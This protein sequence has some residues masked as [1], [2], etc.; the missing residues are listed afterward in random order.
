MKSARPGQEA[1]MIL[2]NHSDPL[3]LQA[4]KAFF[5]N[6]F[7]QNKN[8]LDKY[9]VVKLLSEGAGSL[10]FQFAEAAKAFKCFDS[11]GKPVFVCPDEKERKLIQEGSPLQPKSG[12]IPAQSAGLHVSAL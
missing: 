1:G 6:L 10:Q 5:N 2:R 12:I 4:V 11:P 8:S 7:W 9:N 3:S